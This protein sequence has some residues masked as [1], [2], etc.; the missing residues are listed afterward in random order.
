MRASQQILRYGTTMLGATRCPGIRRANTIS[1]ARHGLLVPHSACMTAVSSPAMCFRPASAS[2]TPYSPAARTM[3]A[4]IIAL[5]S[6]PTGRVR[7]L[8]SA[9]LAESMRASSRGPVPFVIVVRTPTPSCRNS[10]CT[11]SAS[12]LSSARSGGAVVPRGPRTPKSMDFFTLISCPV[13]WTHCPV[14]SSIN[15]SV[16]MHMASM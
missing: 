15:C 5:P 13:S 14:A 9:C 10:C 4:T 3:T 1:L 2:S 11:G 16:M 8:R 6:N 7:T 12:L